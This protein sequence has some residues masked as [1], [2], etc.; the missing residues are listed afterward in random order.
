MKASSFVLV[1][2][3]L[4]LCLLA[5]IHYLYSSSSSSSGSSSSSS[6][7]SGRDTEDIS[8]ATIKQ[9]LQFI[10]HQ[11]R[12][13][14]TLME[15]AQ[16][17]TI[18]TAVTSRSKS[19]AS[20]SSAKDLFKEIELLNQ[21]LVEKESF[22]ESL[23]GAGAGKSIVSSVVAAPHPQHQLFLPPA[24]QPPPQSPPQLHPIDS[25]SRDC[26][27]RYGYSLVQAWTQSKQLWLVRKSNG[28]R[29]TSVTVV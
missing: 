11:N 5:S 4:C 6:S 18:S 12:T 15:S 2:I 10:H 20:V 29:L 16:T 23:T 1:F 13:I 14:Q 24:T 22:I 25:F 17:T 7:R 9:L 28:C 26:D 19:Q 27:A 8:V 3:T 21:L